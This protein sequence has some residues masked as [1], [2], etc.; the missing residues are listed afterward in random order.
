[1]A[2]HVTPIPKLTAFTA[3][4]F[5]LGTSNAAGDAI[6]AVASNSTLLAFDAVLPA[7]TASASSV[8][9]A[10][11]AVRRDHVHASGGPG[12]A[13]AWLQMVYSGGTPTVVGSYNITS[14]TDAATGIYTAVWDTDFGGTDYS[15]VGVCRTGN[16]SSDVCTASSA[17]TTGINIA[18][19]RN[20]TF[21][22]LPS[23]I[24]AFGD[25]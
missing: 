10:T 17:A 24:V 7:V 22:D 14:L 18:M 1:M 5:T 25:Q 8:G 4:A 13:K 2:I 12:V 23:M 6:T 15:V 19:C 9:T 11:V 21:T 3:P 20:G 16:A